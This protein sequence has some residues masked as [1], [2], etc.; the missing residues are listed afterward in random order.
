MATIYEDAKNLWRKFKATQEKVDWRYKPDKEFPYFLIAR[1][2]KAIPIRQEEASSEGERVGAII[3]VLIDALDKNCRDKSLGIIGKT[4]MLES[5]LKK[6]S[7]PSEELL[8]GVILQAKSNE[9]ID[10]EVLRTISTIAN[11]QNRGWTIFID[12][13][14]VKWFQRHLPSNS[15]YDLD[16]TLHL[17]ASSIKAP[18]GMIQYDRKELM[19]RVRADRYGEE[20]LGSN[21]I[22]VDLERLK[23]SG[24]DGV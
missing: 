6:K 24:R 2:D 5:R 11:I 18:R 9:I 13:E 16:N 1:L 21:G 19:E 3:N 12:T 20:I 14:K 17:L 8:T 10:W 23:A 7:I 4:Y 22:G 15:I